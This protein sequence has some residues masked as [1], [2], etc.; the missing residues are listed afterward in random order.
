LTTTRQ[1]A[2]AAARPFIAKALETVPPE[3]PFALDLAG[4]VDA[5]TAAAEPGAL[6]P[7]RHRPEDET[8]AAYLVADAYAEMPALYAMLRTWVTGGSPAVEISVVEADSATSAR[9]DRNEI[10]R[11]KTNAANIRT[12]GM[13]LVAAADHAVKEHARLAAEQTAAQNEEK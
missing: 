11:T 5:V 9:F 4:L 2:I 3:I 6:V 12:L 1:A 7:A 10:V 13:A 8:E